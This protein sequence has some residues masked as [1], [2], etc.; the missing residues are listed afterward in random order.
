MGCLQL[1]LA[2]LLGL[3]GLLLLGEDLGNVLSPEPK[4]R[5]KTLVKPY[6]PE[7]FHPLRIRLN[8]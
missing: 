4:K 1:I 2:L 6:A 5:M 8:L 7:E 3:L